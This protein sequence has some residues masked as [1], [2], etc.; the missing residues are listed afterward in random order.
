MS[1]IQLNGVLNLFKRAIIIVAPGASVRQIWIGFL[2]IAYIPTVITLIRKHF[3]FLCSRRFRRPSPPG[4]RETDEVGV[5]N[6]SYYLIVVEI[7][8]DGID[9]IA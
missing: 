1:F 3:N 5:E 7:A 4:S 9:H 2:E 8:A 6:L